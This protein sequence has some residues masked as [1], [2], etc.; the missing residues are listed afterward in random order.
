MD[1]INRVESNRIN[2]RTETESDIMRR[3]EG[4]RLLAAPR[5]CTHNAPIADVEHKN[6][7]KDSTDTFG[8]TPE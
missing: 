1:R 4:T 7:S 8:F 6:S 5:V 2:A 3:I